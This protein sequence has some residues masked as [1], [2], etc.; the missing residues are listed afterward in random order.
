MSALES[1]DDTTRDLQTE[2][3]VQDPTAHPPQGGSRSPVVADGGRVSDVPLVPSHSSL[4][5]SP[6]LSKPAGAPPPKMSEVSGPKRQKKKK[7]VFHWPRGV[8]GGVKV[9][10]GR[11]LTLPLVAIA[12]DLYFLDA[13]EREKVEAVQEK[14]KSSSGDTSGRGCTPAGLSNAC[15]LAHATS[16]RLLWVY[17]MSL[18]GTQKGS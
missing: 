6:M 10:W 9:E 4:V 16:S 3:P 8:C 1:L 13:T 15:V 2:T 7:C 5:T 12:W 11:D 17:Q 14:E 18:K